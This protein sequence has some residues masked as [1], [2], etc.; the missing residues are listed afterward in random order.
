MAQY[1]SNVG[2]I[3]HRFKQIGV[4]NLMVRRIFSGILLVLGLKKVEKHWVSLL[5]S[6][7]KARAVFTSSTHT[8]AIT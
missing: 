1:V 8:K 6:D 4:H 2:E 7:Y 5:D 3:P